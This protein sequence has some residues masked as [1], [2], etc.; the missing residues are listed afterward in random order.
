MRL[1]LLWLPCV[2]ACASE[3][4][5]KV[6]NSTPT[7]TITS[8]SGTEVFQDGYTVNFQAQVQDDNHE[9]SSLEVVWSSNTRTLCPASPPT[10]D[11]VSQCQVALEEGESIVRV[12]VTDPDDAAAIAEPEACALDK[13]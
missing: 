3:E 2:L 11:G 7:V 12:Q 4:A 5:V 13:P 9:T 1:H 8:H 6:Y 10:A